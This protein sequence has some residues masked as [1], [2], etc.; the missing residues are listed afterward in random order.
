VSEGDTPFTS[1][2]LANQDAICDLLKPF[3][4]RALSQDPKSWIRARIAKLRRELVDLEAKL[5]S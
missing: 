4:M 3:M 1:A 5:E 2:R